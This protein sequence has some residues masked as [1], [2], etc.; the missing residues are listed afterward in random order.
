MG[1]Y[2]KTTCAKGRRSDREGASITVVVGEVSSLFSRILSSRTD[3]DQERASDTDY[4]LLVPLLFTSATIQAVT[5]IVRVT[6]SYRAIELHLPVVLIGVISAVYAILPIFLAVWIGRFMDRGKDAQ[7]AWI[8]SGLLVAACAGFWLFANSVVTLL[9]LTALFGIAQ[10][11]LMASQQMLC[12]RCSGPRGRDSVFGNYLVASAI[13]QGLGPYIIAWSSGSAMVPPT[14]KL[15]GISLAIAALSLLTVGAVRPAAETSSEDKPS[16]LVP[17]KTLLSQRGLM[18]VLV[19]SV[20]TITSQDLLIIYLPL[21]GAARGISAGAVGALL[22]ARSASALVSRLGY[23]RVIRLVPRGILTLSS[24]CGAALGFA[25]LAFPLPLSAMYA[26]MIVMGLSLGIATTLSLTNVV[27]LASQE[28]MGTVMSLRLTGNRIGQV[29]VPF[30]A[31]LV[32]AAT[33]VGGIFVIIAL[34]LAV[35]GATVHFSRQQ[36]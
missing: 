26:A 21:L 13:G 28:V 10:L 11:F 23:S 18:A 6:T 34:G 35:S 15:F 8:G 32:A 4:R 3:F 9:L 19:A 30:I 7:A 14:E 12:I 1:V 5:A 17:V 25:C 29:A 22:T 16:G 31:S 24:M 20:I 36:A 2:T 27:D 33:G